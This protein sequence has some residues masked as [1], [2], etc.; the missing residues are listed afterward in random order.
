MKPIKNRFWGERKPPENRLAIFSA[1]G[2]VYDKAA[3]K[4]SGNTAT[5]RIYG[6]IDSYGSW[7]GV[8]A[9]D[10]AEV[11]DALEESVDTILVRLNSPGGEAFEGVAIMNL[12]RAHRARATAVVDGLAASAASTIATGL[13]ELIMS[14]G[15]ELMIHEPTSF[16]YGDATEMDKTRRMLESVADTIAGVYAA[17]AGTAV[18]DWRA[19][20]AAETWYSAEEAVAAGL[21]DSTGTVPDAGP[22]S[23][24]GE[25][26]DE[27]DDLDDVEDRF[28][29]SIF[30]Y[31]GRSHAP[32]PALPAASA[33]GPHRVKETAVDFSSE[34]IAALREQ[35][36]FAP[37]ADADTIVAAVNEALAERAEP[38]QPPE[39]TGPPP[40]QVAIPEAAY[41]ELQANAAAGAAAAA[42]LRE[43]DREAF[44]D[45][46]RDRFA[47]AN[48]D[49]WRRQ[50]DT[51][52]DGTRTYLEAAP[53]I[54]PLN[55]AGYADTGETTADSLEAVRNSEVY[56]S[57]RI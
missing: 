24:A 4:L 35:V 37:D 40:G 7:W 18:A 56:Q 3:Q 29:L 46:H 45:A 15:S 23:T 49:A 52:P 38:D 47:P 10:V 12:I 13:D 25:G 36:G 21:A 19:A 5:I 33:P 6:P 51:D 57:W 32:A 54:V 41:T 42:T 22:T 20:M 55:E 39:P 27:P 2:P 53:V 31:A 26:E 11:L 8:S 34:Q 28:D 43:R 30:T 14:P 50:Y 9:K 17:K 16:A 1:T 44:L 48:R